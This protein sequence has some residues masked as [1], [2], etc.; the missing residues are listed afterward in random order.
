MFLDPSLF[1]CAFAPL[2]LNIVPLID[3]QLSLNIFKRRGAK[4]QKRREKKEMLPRKIYF[5]KQ[6]N[7]N[8]L[9]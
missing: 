8:N 3:P 2:R 5:Y 7:F 6:L 9:L 4:T 1:L